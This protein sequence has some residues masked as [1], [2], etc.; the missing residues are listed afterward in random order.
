MGRLNKLPEKYK[1]Q[2]R[3]NGQKA[4][5]CIDSG[6]LGMEFFLDQTLPQFNQAGAKLDWGWPETFLDFENVLGDS[7]RT[8]WLEVLAEHY[9]EPL[10]EDSSSHRETKEDF[11]RA[12]GLFI[13]KTL[14]KFCERIKI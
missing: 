11:N 2:G 3:K 13:K 10:N 6:T 5:I 8:T 9:T 4:E 12:V 7:Y 1:F 14:D